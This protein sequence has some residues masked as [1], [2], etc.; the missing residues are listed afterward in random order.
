MLGPE[1]EQNCTPELDRSEQKGWYPETGRARAAT[2]GV[3]PSDF[4]ERFTRDRT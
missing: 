2:G 4:S 3:A 1:G